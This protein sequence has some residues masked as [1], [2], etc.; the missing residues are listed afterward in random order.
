MTGAV[1]LRVVSYGGGVQSTAL[2]VLAAQGRIDFPTFLMANT[3]DDSEHPATLTYV[4]DIAQPY[5]AA[6]SIELHVLD[7]HMVRS[8]AKRTLHEQL[9]DPE[10]VYA[11]IP[12]RMP[13]GAPGKRTC[14]E[15]FK[16]NVVGR[17]LREHGATSETPAVVGI[18]ISLDE[19]SRANNRNRHVY[20]EVVYPL[21]GVGEETG[22]KL[23]RQDCANLIAQAGLEVPPKS[24]CYFCPF[25]SMETWADMRRS[26]PELFE[27]AAQLEAVLNAKRARKDI[28]PVWL[29][30]AMIPLRDAVGDNQGTLLDVDPGCESG[31]C[32]T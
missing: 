18:G 8:G 13:N 17:W 14:T 10:R 19:I 25:H 3:G 6:H 11:G 26:E 12:A 1:P 16:I 30:P 4:R 20:R 22:L 7:R 15:D 23:T 9:T 24:A 2:L 32:M 31:W 28:F 5:A 27:K 29:S 21:I